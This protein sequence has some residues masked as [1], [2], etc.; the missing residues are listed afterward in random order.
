MMQSSVASTQIYHPLS[1][2]DKQRKPFSVAGCRQP[3]ICQA[4]QAENSNIG[5]RTM[6]AVLAAVPMALVVQKGIVGH[7]VI[8]NLLACLDLSV[9]IVL[10]LQ[11]MH[12]SPQTTTRTRNS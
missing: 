10:H 11:L 4:Q 1:H 6:A 7:N 9:D 2:V 3:V 12:L 8:N 5:R